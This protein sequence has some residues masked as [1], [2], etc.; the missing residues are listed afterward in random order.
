MRPGRGLKGQCEFDHV[1]FLPLRSWEYQGLG[2][3]GWLILGGPHLPLEP[4]LG[5]FDFDPRTYNF[6]Q[7]GERPQGTDCYSSLPFANKP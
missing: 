4:P 1:P 2:V 5:A 6:P 3:S 7:G